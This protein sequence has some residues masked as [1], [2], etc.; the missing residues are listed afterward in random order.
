MGFQDFRMPAS[1]ITE[2]YKNVLMEEPGASTGDAE[3]REVVPEEKSVPT[4]K[5]MAE[6]PAKPVPDLPITLTSSEA[7]PYLGGNAKQITLL[8]K[9]KKVLT[10]SAP[11]T[12]FLLKILLACG[13]GMKDIALIDISQIKTGLKELI[14]VQK[15]AKLLLF[16]AE[17]NAEKIAKELCF[18][19]EK[20][21]ETQVLYAPGVHDL[22]KDSADAVQ[23]KKRLWAVLKNFFNV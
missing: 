12:Q 8:A 7:L 3:I 13:L 21:E 15:P 9:G 10:E 18:Q 5:V 1:L 19:I 23:M 17:V 20:L 2:M 11:E 6:V 22:M 4:P 14:E 16:S